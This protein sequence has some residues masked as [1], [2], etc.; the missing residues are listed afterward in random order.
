MSLA[1]NG[2]PR[3]SIV[4]PAYNR[5]EMLRRAVASVLA[6]SWRD[7]EVL[8][9]DDGSAH[10]IA[11]IL[12][13]FDDPRLK[14]IRHDTNRG[15]S[16]ARNTG[17]QAAA[18]EF[19]AFLDS[20]D[21]WLPNCVER[22]LASFDAAGPE[23]VVAYAGVRVVPP[24]KPPRDQ[25]L[26]G[27]LSQALVVR[28]VI[29]STSCVMAR[30]TAL[31]AIGGFDETLPSCQDWDLYI[32]LA[33]LG[34]FEVVEELLVL[35]YVHDD[36]ITASVKASITGHRRLRSKHA[37]AIAALPPPLRAQHEIFMAELFMWKR[38][39]GD[40][41]LSWLR[42]AYA[43]PRVGTQCLD[44]LLARKMQRLLRWGRALVLPRRGGY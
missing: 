32:R 17:I 6:Q 3:V 1:E 33:R 15:A 7:L 27:D 5:V 21:E 2:T 36:S 13:A 26:R 30:R 22:R 29:G 24:V 31:L 16:A 12:S 25:Y 19:V 34:P 43:D 42:A 23:T 28:N 20:D 4:I 9:V 44:R 40:A 41:A 10:D 35:Y 39:W 18:G 38:A 37:E 11:A 14:V 8:V